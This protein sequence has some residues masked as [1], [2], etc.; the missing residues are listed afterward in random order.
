VIGV[1]LGGAN[2]DNRDR[3]AVGDYIVNTLV[4]AADDS[5]EASALY[6]GA[7]DAAERFW[8]PRLIVGGFQDGNIVLNL[9]SYPLQG[10][11]I[12]PSKAS[13]RGSPCPC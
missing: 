11:W 3:R 5:W 9:E 2:S 13:C 8:D 1:A 12:M 7:D 4:R 6:A 10:D